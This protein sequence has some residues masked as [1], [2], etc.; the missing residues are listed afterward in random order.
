M[1]P[2]NPPAGTDPG[3]RPRNIFKILTE[4]VVEGQSREVLES[5]ELL[6]TL[7]RPP[8]SYHWKAPEG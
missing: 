2:A 4:D 7:S 1:I 5:V 3:S 6:D 8:V